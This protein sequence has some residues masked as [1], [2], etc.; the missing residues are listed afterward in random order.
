MKDFYDVILS[1]VVSAISKKAKR[2]IK[3]EKMLQLSPLEAQ[4]VHASKD[5]PASKKENTNMGREVKADIFST[6]NILLTFSPAEV[7]GYEKGSAHSYA[8]KCRLPCQAADGSPA[9]Y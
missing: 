7:P 1:N 9:A 8:I 4:V 6:P 5:R 3:F 2:V